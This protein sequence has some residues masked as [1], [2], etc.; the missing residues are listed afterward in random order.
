[1]LA[2]HIVVNSVTNEI[3]QQKQ[4]TMALSLSLLL[5]HS[6]SSNTNWWGFYFQEH[7][8]LVIKLRSL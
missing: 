7:L 6:L 3:T 1:M 2:A 5:K 8:K 4:I